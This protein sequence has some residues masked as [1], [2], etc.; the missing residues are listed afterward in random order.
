MPLDLGDSLYIIFFVGIYKERERTI[1][2]RHRSFPSP[3][4]ALERT[5]L[6]GNDTAFH[7]ALQVFIGKFFRRDHI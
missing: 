6:Q 2:W 7:H 3:I 1:A 4:N 5:V